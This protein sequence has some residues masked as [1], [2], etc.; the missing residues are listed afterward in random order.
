MG[1][2]LFPEGHSPGHL[3]D[4]GRGERDDHREEGLGGFQNAYI[5]RGREASDKVGAGAPCRAAWAAP[6]VWFQP[7]P[8]D[9]DL[10]R[11]RGRSTGPGSLHHTPASCPGLPRV[12]MRPRHH[13]AGEDSHPVCGN[14]GTERWS[15]TPLL[16]HWEAIVWGLGRAVGS[17]CLRRCCSRCPPQSTW[18]Q[19]SPSPCC[20][21]CLL[22][23]PC[24]PVSSSPTQLPPERKG[25]TAKNKMQPSGDKTDHG[26]VIQDHVAKP[27]LW[28]F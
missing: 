21:S 20:A 22:A 18:P 26:V 24:Y 3:S 16:A 8:L 17:S 4:R 7:P 25:R 10:Q 6:G 11:H 27:F 12:T 14:M 2:G 28:V 15:H 5:N 23:L 9:I 1:Q 13:P 19:P